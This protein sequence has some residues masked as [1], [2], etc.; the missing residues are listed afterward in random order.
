MRNKELI[1]TL[2]V[3]GQGEA[4]SK[5]FPDFY[6]LFT[7]LGINLAFS[8]ALAIIS[9]MNFRKLIGIFSCF[10]VDFRFTPWEQQEMD[11]HKK[12]DSKTSRIRGWWVRPR[13]PCMPAGKVFFGPID[14]LDF[15]FA[16]FI[17]LYFLNDFICSF[18]C[19]NKYFYYKNPM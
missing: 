16:Y 4:N 2:P 9:T 13:A 8:Q 17:H 10:P 5:A 1:D 15:D 18:L 12:F 6:S 19:I 11:T 14:N 7:Q 3:L